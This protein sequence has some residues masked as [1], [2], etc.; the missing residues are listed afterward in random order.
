MRKPIMV[1]LAT[2]LFLAACSSWS[3]SR[4]NPGNWFGKSRSSSIAADVDPASV[5]PLIP[6]K[7]TIS[8]QR[9]AI[10]NSVPIATITEL[11]VEKNSTGATIFVTGV[12]SRQGGYAT[13]LQLDPVTEVSPTDVLSYTFRVNYPDNPTATG[14]ERSRT[15]TEAKSLSNQDLRGIRLIRVKG[16]QNQ[17]ETRRR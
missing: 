3:D 12:A 14:P 4:V 1:L 17:R 8:L 16:A 13:S 15:I 9:D 10:D 11:R 7:A 2:S 5:N 6:R